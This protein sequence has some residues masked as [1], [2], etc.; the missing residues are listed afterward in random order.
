MQAWI[1]SAILFDSFSPGP[2]HKERTRNM[3]K[4][5]CTKILVGVIFF[6][7][8]NGNPSNAQELNIL[9][10]FLKMEYFVTIKNCE[11]F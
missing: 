5:L 11:Q 10:Y 2:Y 9:L 4:V 6:K 7:G 8:K 1:L 3:N